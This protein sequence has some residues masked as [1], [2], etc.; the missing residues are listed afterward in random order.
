MQ[1]QLVGIRNVAP[2]QPVAAIALCAVVLCAT[3]ARAQ[4]AAGSVHVDVTGDARKVLTAIRA[5][6]RVASKIPARSAARVLPTAERYLGV[7]YRWGGTSPKTLRI[8]SASKVCSVAST[9]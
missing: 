9:T 3:D 2:R 1:W 8:A 5:A 7:P 4:L 6:E